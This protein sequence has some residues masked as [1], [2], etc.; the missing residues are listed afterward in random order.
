MTFLGRCFK[1]YNITAIRY[2]NNLV[3]FAVYL[4]DYIINIYCKWTFD[5]NI[6]GRHCCRR[7][8]PT[9]KGVAFLCGFIAKDNLTTVC[10]G[11]SR[12]ALTI[13]KVNHSVVIYGKCTL[14]GNVACRHCCWRFTPTAEGVALFCRCFN[15]CNFTAVS[16]RNNLVLF[17]VN[18]INYIVC[19]HG[20][21]ALYCNITCGHCCRC[22]APTAEG[23]AFLGQFINQS[24]YRAISNGFSRIDLTI[25]K[26]GYGV[27][28]YGKW[29]FNGNVTC[30]HGCRSFTP[31]TK[32]VTLLDW[33]FNQCNFTAVNHR[34][35]LVVFAIYLIYYIITVCCKR[36]L[37]SYILS[38]HACRR[39]APTT[40]GVAFL[41]WFLAQNNFTT[42]S[43]AVNG[44]PNTINLII[45]RIKIDSKCTFDCNITGRH[46]CRCFAP[47]AEGVTFLDRMLTKD[48]FISIKHTIRR[49]DFT[50]YF[51]NHIIA[52]YGKCTLYCHITCRH[53]GW[54]H[55][56]PYNFLISGYS[57]FANPIVAFMHTET[58][59]TIPIS[60][61]NDFRVINRIIFLWKFC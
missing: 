44:K 19:I 39:F 2:R 42:V 57:K 5:C 34:N 35:N 6:L 48:D 47:T 37:N 43:N 8:T 4:V 31:S 51:I 3:L 32:S 29:T 41:I 40:E 45:Y 53:C 56:E 20:I 9:A 14:N 36:S 1:Q 25:Y 26:V 28:V 17:T 59:I 52:V 55:N 11:F 33:L 13:N 24:D 58:D 22:F 21:R 18:L 7:F 50:V 30:R 61:T 16:Y 23:V 27:V 38:R 12:I 49:N 15:Q 10:N 54:R 60:V 46:G